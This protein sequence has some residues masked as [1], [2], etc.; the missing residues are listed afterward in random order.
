[1]AHLLP[2]HMEAKQRGTQVEEEKTIFLYFYLLLV[3]FK[4]SESFKSKVSHTD[5]RDDH[6]DPD[7]LLG[8]PPVLWRPRGDGGS[9]ASV[10][11]QSLSCLTLSNSV[12]CGSPGSS[13]HGISQA[14]IL[15]WFAISFSRGSSRPRDGTH[16][17]YTGRRILYH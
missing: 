12:V 9:Q 4:V 7:S 3:A 6:L 14:R 1:M 13:V 5:L 17:F 11:A 15:E 2:E 16:V 10:C 8:L